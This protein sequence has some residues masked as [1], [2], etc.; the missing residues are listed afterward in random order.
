MEKRI[1]ENIPI[2]GRVYVNFVNLASRIYD[3]YVK[4]NEVDRQKQTQHLG[5]IS[6]AFVGI[7]HT[8]FDYLILQCVISELVENN[9]KGTTTAQGS[10]KIN[11]VEYFGNDII[12][13]WCLLSNF[14]HCKN[15]IGDEKTLLLKAIQSKEFRK[16]LLN[17]IN[18]LELKVWANK[19]IDDL[20]YVN[21]HHILS[22][23]RICKCIPRKV[24][25][26]MELLMVYKVLLFDTHQTANLASSPQVEQ[27]K[28]IYRNIRNLSII[29]L[30]TQNSSLPI[31]ID[32]LSAFLSFDFY[33][34]RYNE[35]RISDLYNPLLSLLY[36]QLYL[37]IKSQTYQRS[38]EII[39][40]RNMPDNFNDVIDKAM[41]EGLSDSRS[42][43]LNHFLRTSLHEYYFEKVDL[44]DSLRNLLTVKREIKDVDASLDF[45][46]FSKVRVYDFY[47]SRDSFTVNLLPKF[48][49]NINGILE[50]QIFG[51]LSNH[52]SL[53][54]GLISSI[55][56]G[57]ERINLDSNSIQV[58]DKLIVKQIY[59]ESWKLIQTGNIPT[60]RDI[61]WAVIRF[62]VKEE[63]YFDIDHHVSK[64]YNYFGVRLHNGIDLISKNI[65]NAIN[66]N[67]D[68]DRI[69][70][71]KQLK[72]STNRKFNGTTIACLARITIYDYSKSPSCRKV[73]D[74]DSIVLKFNQDVMYLEINES[75]NIKRPFKDAK[76]DLNEKLV[77]ILNFN[78][79][80]YRIREVKNFGA[81][82]VIKHVSSII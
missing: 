50:K 18:D 10:I 36:D 54:V 69:H 17:S 1:E 43:E 34:N 59:L 74:I 61:L 29:S 78:T 60:F 51:T 5:L 13:S 2:L 38:Y 52:Y 57:L 32:I 79:K 27:L 33:E 3:V 81:K 68:P 20:D 22:I 30:D 40:L 16:Y 48:L 64:S 77:K 75:K 25:F 56:D 23:R 7:N 66:D 11:N 44:K 9:F 58:I 19:V 15:T 41:V 35:T 12:K 4:E 28:I 53:R 82:L 55:K 45:N 8:R 80:G 37:H 26:R 67:L 72:V 39:S 63:Y 62:H 42:L 73:T 14:G 46:P 71:L 76:K 6:K 31:T 21:F 49:Y 47:T 70:E 65:D 24:L